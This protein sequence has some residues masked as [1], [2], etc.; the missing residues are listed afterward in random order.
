MGVGQD[1]GTG[2]IQGQRSG[3]HCVIVQVVRGGR[4]R[5]W[6]WHYPGTKKWLSLCHSLGRMCTGIVLGNGNGRS[7]CIRSIQYYESI[8][9]TNFYY[10]SM[11][12]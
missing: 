3:C 5:P 10:G 11:T 12:F 2:I 4:P 6:H 8:R 7:R 9:L 1:H